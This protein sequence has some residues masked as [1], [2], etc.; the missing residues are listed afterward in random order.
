MLLEEVLVSF[1][2]EGGSVRANW[3]RMLSVSSSQSPDTEGV[4][5]E[6]ETSTSMED[7]AGLSTVTLDMMLQKL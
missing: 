4:A 6:A 1:S 5:D 3:R 7:I 2:L